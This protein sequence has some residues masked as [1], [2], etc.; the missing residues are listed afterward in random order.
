MLLSG[1]QNKIF[2]KPFRGLER[3]K[4]SSQYVEM[5]MILK[6][7]SYLGQLL[8]AKDY[9]CLPQTIEGSEAQT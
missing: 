8:T 5:K 7:R 9:F 4:Q 6:D 1:Q 2:L 3:H